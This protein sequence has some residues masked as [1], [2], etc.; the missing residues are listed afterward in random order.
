MNNSF[1]PVLRSFFSDTSDPYSEFNKLQASVD[2]LFNEFFVQGDVP[3]FTHLQGNYPKVNV[4]ETDSQFEIIA[5]TPGLTKD[6]LSVELVNG[7]LQIKGESKQDEVS[8]GDRFIYRELKKSSFSRAFKLD[9]T[10][11]DTSSIKSSYENGELRVLLPKLKEKI[12]DKSV[13][14]SID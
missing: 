6:E 2:S 7:I 3:H 5:A 8:K 14:I 4:K 12:K 13:R 11:I 10:K 1:F 9:E